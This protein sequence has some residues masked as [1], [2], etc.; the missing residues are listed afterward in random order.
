MSKIVILIGSMRKGGN[1]ELLAQ[2]FVAGAQAHNETE[3][4]S[5]ADYEIKPCIGCNSCFDRE[6]N[7]C[8]QNDDMKII[9]GKLSEADI[10]AVASPVYFY[11]ISS[12]LKALI[13]RLHTPL[14][15]KFKI[16][17]SVLLLVAASTVPTV[18]DAVKI[19]YQLILDFFKIENAGMIL[20][21][22]VKDKGDI[23]G[24]QALA[25]AYRLGNSLN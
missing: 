9:Y 11:G 6:G 3:I 16:K 4:I 25:E 15:N 23:N 13:D 18:F 1:T 10:V 7:A 17:K 22:G 20:V 5:V 14:R 2:A 12:Q 19:Q 24:N 21:S 8:F